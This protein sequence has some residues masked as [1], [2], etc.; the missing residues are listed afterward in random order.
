MLG[1]G[2]EAAQDGD[3]IGIQQWIDD[4]VAASSRIT[5]LH[6][7]VDQEISAPGQPV[8]TTR[9]EFYMD[10]TR[11][12]YSMTTDEAG[13]S[14]EAVIL[15]GIVYVKV[16]GTV[17]ETT[18]DEMGTSVAD[19]NPVAQ[20]ERQSGAMTKVELVG[21]EKVGGV[22]TDHYVVTYD[23]A[24]LEEASAPA[25]GEVQG[26]TVTMHHWLDDEMRPIKFTATTTEMAR[27]TM[28]TV[29]VEVVY[30]DYGKPVTIEVPR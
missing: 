24:E 20:A 23:V 11:G 12:A 22:Q 7:V 25:E 2:G 3:G 29:K 18:L 15:D 9:T 16:D 30:S 28:I 27:G 1:D 21:G 8:T 4:Y 19:L 5:T 17:R 13:G 26:D 6:A 10:A 14:A